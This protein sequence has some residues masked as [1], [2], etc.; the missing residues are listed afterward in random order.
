M[1]RSQI[2]LVADL[3]VGRNLQDHIYP[4]GVHFTI[5]KPVSLTQ[6]RIFTLKNLLKY[7]SKGSG[8]LAIKLNLM[9]RHPNT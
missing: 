6:K 1:I 2:P 9:S 4:G 8:K 5:D 3:P 7:F